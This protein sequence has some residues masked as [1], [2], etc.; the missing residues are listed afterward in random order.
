MHLDPTVWGIGDRSLLDIRV[1]DAR[2]HLVRTAGSE[3]LGVAQHGAVWPRV[4]ARQGF[5]PP[6]PNEVPLTSPQ[7]PAA[8]GDG[9]FAEQDKWVRA[10]TRPVEGDV[11]NPE[12]VDRVPAFL[13]LTR[14]RPPRQPVWERVQDRLQQQPQQPLAAALDPLFRDVW[15]RLCDPTLHRPHRLTCWRILHACL[16]CNAF[17]CYARGGRGACT[18]SPFCSAATCAGRNVVE[19]LTHAFIDCP[20][21]APVAR[22]LCDTWRALAG[23]EPPCMPLVLLCD[24]PRAWPAAPDRQAF[25]LWTRLRVAT[26]GSV[27]RLRC[28]RARP[29]GDTRSLAHRAVKDAIRTVVNAIQR[30]WARAQSDVR[31]DDEGDLDRDWWSAVDVALDPRRFKAMWASPP[32]LCSVSAGGLQVR[33]SDQ[34]PVPVPPA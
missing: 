18:T 12:D 31:Y 10:A 30:D 25:Q 13:D 19:T 28:A 24:D 6:D 34:G 11:D 3:V 9:L 23:A 16:G 8:R 29:D 15:T 22:W 32:I 26:L 17:L 20:E 7:P 33:L 1:R 2:R 5:Q 21:V 14:Q 27:W 4:W